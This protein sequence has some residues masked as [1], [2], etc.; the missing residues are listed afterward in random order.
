[1]LRPGLLARAHGGTIYVDG[2]NLLPDGSANLLLGALENGEVR[3][4]R[5]GVSARQS[6]RF[7]LIGSYDP[8]EGA[9]RRHMIDRVGL[10]LV[11]PAATSAQQ[12]AEV[13]RRN[14][15]GQLAANHPAG[16]PRAADDLPATTWDDELALLQGLVRAG[17]EQLPLVQIDDAQIDQLA[18]FALACGVG[19]TA[20]TPLPCARPAPPPRW[21]CAIMSGLKISSW[22]RAW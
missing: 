13:V 1:M 7:R 18:S 11:L 12:R 8:A 2:L 16:R 17:R 15:A 14:L 21:R 9:P 4:E 19:A 6:A 20:P 3:I 22:P 10:L 5:E